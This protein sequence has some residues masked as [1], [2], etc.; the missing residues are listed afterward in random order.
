VLFIF[1]YFPIIYWVPPHEVQKYLKANLIISSATLFGI[2]GWA[3]AQNGGRVGD[4]VSPQIDVPSGQVGF[5]MVQGISSIAG[6]YAGGS[7]R[8]SDWTRYAKTRVSC[9]IFWLWK[10]SALRG[11]QMRL[12]N[13]HLCS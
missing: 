11:A 9:P 8:V 2:M 10:P 13:C 4:L 5:L 12:V 6:T 1:V 7:D 3:I